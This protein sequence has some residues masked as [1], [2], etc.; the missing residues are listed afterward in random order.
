MMHVTT[1]QLCMLRLRILATSD[2]HAN[3]LPW[4]YYLDRP[5]EGHGLARVAS[6]LRAAKTEVG[7]CLFFDNGDLIE[8]SPLAEYAQHAADVPMGPHPMIAALNALGCDA[9]TL[10]NHEF[11]YGMP[12]LQ[13]VLRH[14]AYPVVC[15]N[16]LTAKGKDTSADVTLI[17]PWVILER[18]FEDMMEV[19]QPVRIGVLGLTP[20]QV[21]DWDRAVLQGAVQA[22]D[23]VEAARYHIP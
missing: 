8:G 12:Y 3:L 2:L 10:G 18:Q 9:A 21:L 4:D 22:R 17:E 5:L 15:A 16:I 7:N 13:T 1:E 20:P 19:Q 11:S 23:M 14:A 6:L